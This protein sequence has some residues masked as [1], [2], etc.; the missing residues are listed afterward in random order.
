MQIKD[1]KAFHYNIRLFHLRKEGFGGGL[2]RPCL[3]HTAA[4]TQL[5]TS[6]LY[7]FNIVILLTHEMSCTLRALSGY[8]LLHCVPKKRPPFYFSYN[9]VKN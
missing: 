4:L 5:V 6:K 9:S 8:L 3:H 1:S 7:G 2:H